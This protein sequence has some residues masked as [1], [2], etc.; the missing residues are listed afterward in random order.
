MLRC[1][2][3]PKLRA[4]SPPPLLPPFTSTSTVMPR[5]PDRHCCYLPRLLRDALGD[6]RLIFASVRITFDTLKLSEDYD[7]KVEMS[8]DLAKLAMR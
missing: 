5:L 7:L 8:P 2:V 4:W 1:Q 6:P 3:A